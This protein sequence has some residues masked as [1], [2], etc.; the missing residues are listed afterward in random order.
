MRAFVEGCASYVHRLAPAQLVTVGSAR[1]KWLQLWTGCDLD[2]YQ[3]H[4]YDHFEHEE[5]FPWRPYDELGLD[6]PC[7]IGEVPTGNTKFRP[8]EFI[9][10]A[11]DGGYS[12]LLFWS[13]TARDPFSDVCSMLEGRPVRLPPVIRWP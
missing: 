12:G 3:F 8:E 10:A 11:E 6:Q 7:L 4:W 5:P 1:R 9:A 13:Y 2:L